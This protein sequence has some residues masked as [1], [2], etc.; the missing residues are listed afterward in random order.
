MKLGNGLGRPAFKNTT[1]EGAKYLR[2][3]ERIAR[4]NG[5]ASLAHQ[6]IFLSLL[7]AK[8]LKEQDDGAQGDQAATRE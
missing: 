6:T 1:R 3:K 5:F 2:K 8:R 7:A 4:K